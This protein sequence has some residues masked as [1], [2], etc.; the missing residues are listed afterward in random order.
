MKKKKTWWDSFVEILGRTWILDKYKDS[1][2]TE[3]NRRHLD[4]FMKRCQKLGDKAYFFPSSSLKD[5]VKFVFW[6]FFAS[7][8]E[9][10]YIEFVER[11]S[12]V[13]AETKEK[14]KEQQKQTEELNA[15]LQ[16]FNLEE[17]FKL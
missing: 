12:K 14:E 17:H 6:S 2:F 13:H 4:R 10:D 7:M 9:L 15:S 11:L 1:T 16:S 3:R 8:D 5:F